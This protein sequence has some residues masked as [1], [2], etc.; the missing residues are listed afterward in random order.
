VLGWGIGAAGDGARQW[1]AAAVAGA[2]APASSRP[3]QGK[4]QR[5]RHQ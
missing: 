2:P 1:Y 5:G 4:G 3:G